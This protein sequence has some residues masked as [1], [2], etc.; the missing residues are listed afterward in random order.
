MC[1]STGKLYSL[2]TSFV[3]GSIMCIAGFF[4]LSLDSV[5]TFSVNPVCSSTSSR[6]VIPSITLSKTILPFASVM[7]TALYGS[8]LQIK[9]SFFIFLPFL[10]LIDDP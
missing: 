10:M 2:K 9:S 4:F 6:N 7:I 3:L 5:I 8:H 1:A